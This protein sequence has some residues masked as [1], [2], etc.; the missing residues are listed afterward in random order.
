MKGSFACTAE[1]LAQMLARA[2]LLSAF[3]LAAAMVI[4]HCLNP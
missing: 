4:A 1:G 3:V 2:L